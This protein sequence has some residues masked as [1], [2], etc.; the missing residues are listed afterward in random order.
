MTARKQPAKRKAPKTTRSIR[1]H[2]TQPYKAKKGS[3]IGWVAYDVGR[4]ATQA[5][6]TAKGYHQ[7]GHEAIVVKTPG[8]SKGHPFPYHIHVLEV[9]GIPRKVPKGQ[10]P[11][12]VTRRKVGAKR[13]KK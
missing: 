6:S 4:S 12:G 1:L 13:K 10:L 8:W 7:G 5:R 3:P 9:N 11:I 2:K